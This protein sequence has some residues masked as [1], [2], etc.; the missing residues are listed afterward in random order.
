MIRIYFLAAAYL[1]QERCRGQTWDNGKSR[2]TVFT[3]TYRNTGT[4]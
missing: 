3:G 1:G 2:V 4:N